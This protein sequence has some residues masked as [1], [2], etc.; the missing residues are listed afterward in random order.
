MHI[1]EKKQ[2]TETG[3]SNRYK[4]IWK[5]KQN[6]DSSRKKEMWE[7]LPGDKWAG[8]FLTEINEFEIA[9]IIV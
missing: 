9:A 5:T 3:L 4:R 1:K 8:G 6:S 2:E 7:K